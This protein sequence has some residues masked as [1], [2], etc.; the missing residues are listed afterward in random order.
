MEQSDPGAK[1]SGIGDVRRSWDA[2]TKFLNI[3]PAPRVRECPSCGVE[4]MYAASRCM[5]CWA[6]SLPA[7]GANAGESVPT[8]K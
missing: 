2:L 7:D 8:I 6:K 5:H 3:G 1:G 4:I